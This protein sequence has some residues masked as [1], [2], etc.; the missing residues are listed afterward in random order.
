MGKTFR[1]FGGKLKTKNSKT[2]LENFCSLSI[3]QIA[4][5]IFPLIT[6]P[7]LARVIGA[8]GFGYIAFAA[9]IMIWLQTIV[10]WGFSY[11]ATR[12]VAR[13]RNNK[14]QLSNILSTVLAAKLFLMF[15]SAFLLLG[16]II[17]IPALKKIY[18]LM[19]FS[20]LMI[21]GHIL[22]P[23]WFFQGM[24]RMK[25]LTMLNLMAKTFFTLLVF[26]VVQKKSDY[27]Y[28]PLLTSLAFLLSGGIAMYVITQRWNIHLKRPS[29]KAIMSALKGSTDV[30]INQIVPNLYNSFSVILVGAFNGSVATGLLNG[31]QKIAQIESQFL[32]NISRVFYP[33]LATRIDRH[34]FF[35]L[36]TL[37]LTISISVITIL[38][39]RPLIHLLLGSEFLPSIVVLRIQA[40]TIIFNMMYNVYGV[41]FMMLEGYE[42]QLRKITFIVSLGCFILAIPLAYFY[43]YIGASITIL[44]ANTLIG[45]STAKFVLNLQKTATK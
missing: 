8:E 31:G 14:E 1:L 16:A 2:L 43:S 39:A 33:F 41:N 36:I 27:I 44:V 21:P 15:A 7:Y 34:K 3:L 12:D 35:A 10:D 28:Q 17:L 26:V 22:F 9:S 42:R 45:C 30:F 5:Y 25:Y 6:L 38:L 32:G 18:L 19:F 11:T 20:F 40:V 4:G 37:T 29:T 13:N 24:E 23:D